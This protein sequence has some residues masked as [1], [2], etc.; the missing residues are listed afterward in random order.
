M[1]G[2][3]HIPYH[4]LLRPAPL[5][6]SPAAWAQYGA[7][8]SE[9]PAAATVAVALS[10]LAAAC[11]GGGGTGQSSA[12]RAPAGATTSAATT[13]ADPAD[14]PA[15]ASAGCS[16]GAGMPSGAPIGG[17]EIEQ[18]LVSSGVERR[19]FRFAP[20]A[21]DGVTPLPLVIDLHG[22]S[23]GAAIQ[24]SMSGLETFGEEQSFAVLTPQG[25]GEIPY[26]NALAHEDMIDDVRFV[27]DLIGTTATGLCIDERRVYVTGLSM[28]AF[29]TSLVGCRLADRVAAIA[30]VAGLRFPD[31]CAPAAPVPVVAFHGTADE[32]VT[33]DGHSGSGAASLSFDK[34]TKSAFSGFVPQPV[35]D[36]LEG[37]ARAEGCARSPEEEGVTAAVTLIRYGACDGG[38]VVELYRAKASGHTWPGSEFSAAIEDVVG[39]TTFDID[40]DEIMW[41]F[42]LAHP[43]PD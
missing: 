11:S 41:A 18:T 42:F 30:P 14:L 5:P 20:S 8:M 29:M 32:F 10:V 34:E 16:S 9:R 19:Y 25:L 7:P 4:R 27:S 1:H 2:W 38:S 39:P 43:L 28:G 36:A 40:A 12:T 26:W 23:E 24:R 22:Y 21:Y 15:R 33:Y 17:E 37:W 31:D 3:Y 13:N 6:Y 35:P